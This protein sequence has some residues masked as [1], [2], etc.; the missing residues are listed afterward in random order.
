[1]GNES[2]D[3][4]LKKILEYIYGAGSMSGIPSETYIQEILNDSNIKEI[5]LALEKDVI[6]KLNDGK[7]PLDLE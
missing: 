7:K 3:V 2:A 4:K 5:I 6:S 1:M